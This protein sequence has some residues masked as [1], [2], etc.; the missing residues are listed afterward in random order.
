MSV[1]HFHTYRTG[2]CC[3]VLLRGCSVAVPCFHH[4]TGT[5]PEYTSNKYLMTLSTSN[6]STLLL[7]TSC[8]VQ[9]ISDP[10]LVG[11]IR[12][13]SWPFRPGEYV[14][15]RISYDV[16]MSTRYEDISHLLW[17][18]LPGTRYIQSMSMDGYPTTQ[19]VFRLFSVSC[20]SYCRALPGS[21]Q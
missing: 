6:K 1:F 9:Y 21:S 17:Y 20:H 3:C 19:E 10:Y 8:T 5:I 14:V 11:H 15:G 7:G 13:M 18:V 16:C 4:T 12:E 2:C